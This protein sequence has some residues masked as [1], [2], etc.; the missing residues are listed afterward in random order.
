MEKPAFEQ[1]MQSVLTKLKDA[2][3][4][5]NGDWLMRGLID[6][7]NRVFPIPSDTKVISKAIELAIVPVLAESLAQSEL[8]VEIAKHQ[9]YY[10]D[11]TLKHVPT[12][13][14]FAVDIKTTYRSEDG[15]VSGITLGT[16]TGYF[17]E[18]ESTKNICYPYNR[19]RG[20]YVLGVIY[21]RLEVPDSQKRVYA[22]DDLEQ[23]PPLI[24]DIQVFFQEKYK[25]ASDKP[26][27]GNTSNI[28]SVSKLQELISG[29]G[30]FAKLGE[31]VFDDYWMN[32]ETNDMARRAGRTAPRYTNLEA[33]KKWKEEL[34]EQE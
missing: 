14:L 2:I 24:G 8:K 16:Y 6:I 13:T 29:E 19:Y 3:A 34:G 5:E 21:S 12:D 27:S 20:H 1:L 17:R 11:V 30:P 9:N 33:Y 31:T 32:Y 22:L 10:P 26:G 7:R 4:I 25:I 23:I 18:R 15:K 28:G